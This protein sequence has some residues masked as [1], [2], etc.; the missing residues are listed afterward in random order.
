[1]ACEAGRTVAF[2]GAWRDVLASG[3]VFARRMCAAIVEVEIAQHTAPVGPTNALPRAETIAV[4]AARI[5]ETLVATRARPARSALARVW[6]V[7]KAVLLVAANA[8]RGLIALEPVPAV[9]AHL[10][11]GERAVVV[12]ELVVARATKRRAPVAVVVGRAVHSVVVVVVESQLVCKQFCDM[13][14]KAQR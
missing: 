4:L 13:M 5:R 14:C 10:L 1:M 3:V 12:A 8:T 7:T 2:V 6:F 9:E 11:A